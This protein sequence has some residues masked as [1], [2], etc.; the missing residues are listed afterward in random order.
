MQEVYKSCPALLPGFVDV[1]EKRPPGW[2]VEFWLKLS[3]QE[4]GGGVVGQA[5]GHH[6]INEPPNEK[7]I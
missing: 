6:R 4:S 3:H 2:D 7:R 5:D 1:P